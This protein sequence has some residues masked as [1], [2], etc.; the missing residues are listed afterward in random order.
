MHLGMKRRLVFL[1]ALSSALAV[2]WCAASDAPADRGMPGDPNAFE[3]HRGEA[4]M[5]SV[6]LL[7]GALE[8]DFGR[9]QTAMPERGAVHGRVVD[10]DGKAVPDVLVVGGEGLTVLS[11]V[12]HGRDGAWTD[13]DG[14]FTVKAFVD[15]EVLLVAAHHEYGMSRVARTWVGADVELTLEPFAWVEGFVREGASPSEARVLVQNDDLTVSYLDHTDAHGH[16]MVGPVPPGTYRVRAHDQASRDVVVAFPWVD[17]EVRPGVRTT[18]DIIEVDPGSVTVDTR[19]TPGMRAA[20]VSVSLFGGRQRISTEEQYR[21]LLEHAADGGAHTLSTIG[22]RE[23]VVVFRGVPAGH[24][25][26]CAE[27]NLGETG[28]EVGCQEVTVGDN[29][30]PRVDLRL[31]AG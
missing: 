4:G 11:D 3:L 9:A 24:Y 13:E 29:P 5:V 18:Q 30:T 22:S 25:T 31:H 28:M 14:R 10:E 26:A 8:D 21:H 16:Y 19:R 6:H 15:D 12:L 2:G 1:A 20:T 7:G 17:V 23:E 27:W